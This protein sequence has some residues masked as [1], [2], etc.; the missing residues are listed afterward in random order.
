M[1]AKA[2]YFMHASIW[3]GQFLKPASALQK[4]PKESRSPHP[5]FKWHLMHVLTNLGHQNLFAEKLSGLV[6]KG[7][8]TS[9]GLINFIKDGNAPGSFWKDVL[10]EFTKLIAHSKR[11]R[12][13]VSALQKPRSKPIKPKLTAMS[14]RSRSTSLPAIPTHNTPS[15]PGWHRVKYSLENTKV[16]KV[17][18]HQSRRLH[19]MVTTMDKESARQKQENLQR[20]K[21]E[22]LKLKKEYDFLRKKLNDLPSISA[23]VV[24]CGPEQP[25]SKFCFHFK[26]NDSIQ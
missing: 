23:A 5:V 4:P 7:V 21:R 14:K 12:S 24:E 16:E 15:N 25:K 19:R 6:S 20:A 26:F 9:E 18:R 3:L 13:T 11:S 2:F 22:R 17:S 1:V 8:T 10:S